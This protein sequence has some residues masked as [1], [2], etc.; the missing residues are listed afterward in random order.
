MARP[1][2]IIGLGGT[3]QWVLTY[4]KKDLLETNRGQ[5]PSNVRLLVFDT[6]PQATVETAQAGGEKEVKVGTI[7]LTTDTEFVHLGGNIFDLAN[8]V[9][10]DDTRTSVPGSR[11][12][13]TP[14]ICR[15]PPST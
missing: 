8:Q 9:K 1:A 10:R 3:G 11:L 4:I 6:M 15:R 2:V 7:K 14:A 12:T 5:L 13:T